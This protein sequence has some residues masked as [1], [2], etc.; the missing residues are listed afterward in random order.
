MAS[1]MITAGAA[2]YA[3]VVL[4]ALVTATINDFALG[5][6]ET[7]IVATIAEA[8]WR[9]CKAFS[10]ANTLILF[11]DDSFT[12]SVLSRSVVATTWVGATLL[13]HHT[14]VSLNSLV[15]LANNG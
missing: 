9:A 10:A 11:T 8:S 15:G 14:V 13:T 3:L 12:F 4:H 6:H 2:G 5:I 7:G 1:W